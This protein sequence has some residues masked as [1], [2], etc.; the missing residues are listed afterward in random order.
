MVTAQP[1]AP[2][3]DR[4]VWPVRHPWVLA[5]VFGLVPVVFTTVGAAYGQIRQLDDPGVYTAVA[6]AVTLSALVGALVMWRARPSFADFGFRAPEQARA[7][8][9]FVPCALVVLSVLIATGV[10]TPPATIPP[11]LWLAV[12]VGFNEEIWYRGLSVT[13]LRVLGTRKAL[14]GGAIVFGVLHLVNLLNPGVTM[15]YALLQLLFAALFGF[16]AA[17]IFVV[18]RSLWPVIV[19]HAAY[20]FTAYIGGD[21]LDLRG[22]LGTGAAT[23][24]LVAYAAWLWRQIPDDRRA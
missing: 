14:V 1:N 21:A 4:S 13:A 23:V 11:L 15:E 22:L 16:V 17:E 10:A 24:V 5:V 6:V 3:S 7:A 8:L 2:L 20:D 9:W 18:T 19:W 12:A